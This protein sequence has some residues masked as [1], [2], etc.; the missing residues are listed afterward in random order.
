MKG[1][2]GQRWPRRSRLSNQS[3]GHLTLDIGEP[4]I[5]TS[6]VAQGYDIEISAPVIEQCGWT[7]VDKV[8]ERE[9]DVQLKSMEGIGVVRKMELA[10]PPSAYRLDP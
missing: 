1:F 3:D 9:D 8:E 5:A 10:R 2:M 6:P 7:S 4:G